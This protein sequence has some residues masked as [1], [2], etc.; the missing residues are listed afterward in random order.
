MSRRQDLRDRTAAVGGGGTYR[1]PE[2]VPPVSR[3]TAKSRTDNFAAELILAL[4]EAAAAPAA[5]VSPHQTWGKLQFDW[6]DVSAV[7]LEAVARA[8]LDSPRAALDAFPLSETLVLTVEDCARPRAPRP[9]KPAV[10]VELATRAAVEEE[11]RLAVRLAFQRLAAALLTCLS[12]L[13]GMTEEV[14]ATKLQQ[15][16]CG[17]APVVEDQGHPGGDEAGADTPPAPGGADNEA[18]QD[19]HGSDSSDWEDF[20]VPPSSAWPGP[21][22]QAG[23]AAGATPTAAD[24]GTKLAWLLSRFSYRMVDLPGVWAEAK[25]TGVVL[26]ILKALHDQHRDAAWAP[27]AGI[28]LCHLLLDRWCSSASAVADA[29]LPGVMR[30]LASDSQCRDIHDDGS[31]LRMLARLAAQPRDVARAAWPQLH[32]C[33]G[34][35]VAPLAERLTSASHK[36]PVEAADEAG[37]LFGDVLACY[38]L[39]A[40]GGS[41]VGGTLLRTGA[42]RSAAALLASAKAPLALRTGVL[43]TC[44]RAPEAC[45][46]VAA[47]AGASA[48]L[49]DGSGDAVSCLWPLVAGSSSDALC[50]VL[51]AAQGG[52][53]VAVKEA[54]DKLPVLL[55]CM[56]AAQAARPLWRP[57]DAVHAAL[58]A[59]QSSLRGVSLEEPPGE[60]TTDETSAADKA[61]SR[62]AA[63]RQ[64]VKEA[65]STA[66]GTSQKKD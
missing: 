57:G 35:V 22:P 15:L 8:L 55:D 18:A 47:V 33:M 31:P 60:E 45:S 7:E 25:L 51:T 43:V 65:L 61:H 1:V 62:R 11:A 40:P 20:L 66:D 12:H 59:L 10:V 34:D 48:A 21:N 56:R 27:H 36:Q 26:T 50:S 19:A 52:E 24:A 64:L 53:A 46:Y 3:P 38:A 32:V 44:A 42:L 37:S 29:D 23:D 41:D 4:E 16:K 54:Q 9:G 49:A 63:L 28:H 14:A 5:P 6:P 39:H 30:L 13:A 17:A 2:R 58:L